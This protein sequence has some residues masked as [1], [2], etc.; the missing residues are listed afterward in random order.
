MQIIAW[1]GV[2]H[3]HKADWG[4]ESG[5]TVTFKLPMTKMED[6]RNPFENFTKRRKGRAGTRF[7][8]AVTTSEAAPQ[9]IYKDEVML[10]GWN[11]SQSTGHTVKFWLCNDRMGHP[12]EGISRK[13]ELALALSELDD[14]NEPIDQKMRDRVEGGTKRPSERLSYVAAMLCKGVSF[15]EWCT[16]RLADQEIPFCGPVTDEHSARGYI[17]HECGISSRAELD[18]PGQHVQ[19]FHDQIRKPYLVWIG[20]HSEEDPF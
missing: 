14:D 4:D 9:A 2:V 18:Q 10:A 16:Q 12:F 19:L 8:M 15:H 6:R 11:D 13:Q 7:F 5:S 17:L 3:M 1:H 20:E